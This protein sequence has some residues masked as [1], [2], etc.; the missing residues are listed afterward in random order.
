M[1]HTSPIPLPV[2]AISSTLAFLPIIQFPPQRW[3]LHRLS[4]FLFSVTSTMPGIKG[5]LYLLLTQIT[6]VSFSPTTCCQH[7]SSSKQVSHEHLRFR[8]RQVVSP[9]K[10]LPT[11]ARPQWH[12]H[13]LDSQAANSP[14]PCPPT[15]G[16]SLNPINSISL[17]FC[18]AFFPSFPRVL[19]QVL[20]ASALEF[21]NNLLCGFL[22]AFPLL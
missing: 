3:A 6:S 13:F 10:P 20:N 21:S 17:K 9:P 22:L 7:D 11:T 4:H 1:T 2:L 16:E 12:H 5:L 19:V 8:A 18:N 15:K 14:L